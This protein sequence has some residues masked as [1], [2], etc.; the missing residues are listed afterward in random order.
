MNTAQTIV[1]IFT[2]TIILFIFPLMTMADQTDKA[3]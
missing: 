2:G 1:V 3:T